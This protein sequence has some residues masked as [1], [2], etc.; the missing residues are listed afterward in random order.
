MPELEHRLSHLDAQAFGLVGTGYGAAVVV[1][2]HDYRQAFEIGP[3]DPLAADEEIVAVGQG[4]HRSDF[5]DDVAYRSPDDQIVT[6][7]DCDCL[8][9]R[10]GGL[11]GYA[12]VLME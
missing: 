6:F 5:L 11:Q 9:F 10:I 3:E 8:V 2:E 7:A 1:G 4:V 12:S